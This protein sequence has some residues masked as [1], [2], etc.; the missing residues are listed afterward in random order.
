MAFGI[1][2]LLAC[3]VG[4]LTTLIGFDR[5]RALYPVILIVVASYYCLFATMGGSPH[6]LGAEMV[7]FAIFGCGAILGFKTSLWWVV[8]GLAAHGAMDLFHHNL[9]ENSG[10][11]I[12]W[13]VFCA[14]YD[15]TAAAYLALVISRT[16]RIVAA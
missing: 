1:G 11:P 9:V 14:A 16:K 15:V 4:L 8:A 12:W 5:D 7:I 6:A 10:V 2:I 13:P 3:F